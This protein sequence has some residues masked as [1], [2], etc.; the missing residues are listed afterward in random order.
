MAAGVPR[1]ALRGPRWR[2]TS[3]GFYVAAE[4]P[5]ARA[6]APSHWANTPTV[7]PMDSVHAHAAPI[8]S[9]TQRILDCT[10]FLPAG[11]AFG[12]WAAGYAAGAELLDG[13]APQ[14]RTEMPLMI[15]LGRDVGRARRPGVI[16]S[17]ERLQ[18]GD[19]AT[20]AG[21]PFTSAE[22]TAFDG[23]RLA[24]NLAEAV[25]FV[26]A[27][28]HARL[29]SLESVWGYARAHSGFAGVAQAR[30]AIA[31]ADAASRNLWESRLRV[32]YM[33]EVGL[34][35]PLVNCPVFNFDGELMGIPDLLDDKAGYVV[36]FDGE[37]HR[38]RRQHRSDNVREERFEAAGLTVTRVD[39]LDLGSHRSELR[40]RL[41]AGYARAQMRRRSLDRW[42]TVE[43][44][45]WAANEARDVLTDEEKHELYGG[46]DT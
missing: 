2:R 13:L 37:H 40:G 28:L 44:S 27:M 10:P 32:F 1:G 19:V 4:S 46:G 38:N 30:A 20:V 26:D 12:T 33:R 23:A 34:P 5:K 25:A 42:T 17:R 16:F 18:A 43:P 29:V 39:S 24:P 7:S 22:K 14:G 3:Y 6:N 36:E 21:W 31:M 45:W 11:G 8:A 15:Y 41:I 35:R 9:P